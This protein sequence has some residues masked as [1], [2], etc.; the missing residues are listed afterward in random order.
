M[1]YKHLLN[2][3]ICI[4]FFLLGCKNSDSPIQDNLKSFE[5]IQ[6]DFIN[7]TDDNNLWCYW[8]WINDDISKDG[9]TKDLEAMKK[10][11]IGGALIGNINP[12]RKDGKVP[13]LSEEWWSHMVHAVV[14]GKRSWQHY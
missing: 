7:P 12:T 6:S 14:E 13:M 9:I 11:G 2:I 8:Y 4:L 1:K 10:A 3:L 5:S